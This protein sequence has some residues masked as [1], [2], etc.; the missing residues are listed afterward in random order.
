MKFNDTH[1][2]ISKPCTF[3]LRRH[4]HSKPILLKTELKTLF[5]TAFKCY[6]HVSGLPYLD[7]YTCTHL[8]GVCATW[9]PFS[10]LFSSSLCFP[11]METYLKSWDFGWEP[12]AWG[13]ANQTV[14]W[15]HSEQ[16]VHTGLERWD[17]AKGQQEN[18]RGDEMMRVRMWG[19]WGKAHIGYGLHRPLAAAHHSAILG[20]IHDE[21]SEGRKKENKV[22]FGS[23][24]EVAS[25]GLWAKNDLPWQEA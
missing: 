23:E 10:C 18:C 19:L 8:C 4:V 16:P 9:R 21:A 7:S 5:S 2:N 11:K 3:K 1:F 14:E 24:T 20:E 17:R 6:F 15:S 12:A 25:L 13:R 22:D